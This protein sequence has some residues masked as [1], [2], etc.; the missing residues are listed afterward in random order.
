M[1]PTSRPSPT[2]G[3]P[4]PAPPPQL[5]ITFS[6]EGPLAPPTLPLYLHPLYPFL[7]V[8]PTNM[9]ALICS[10]PLHSQ[11]LGFSEAQSLSSILSKGETETDSL[12]FLDVK[13]HPQPALPATRGRC[14]LSCPAQRG[15]RSRIWDGRKGRVKALGVWVGPVQKAGL[16]R[17]GRGG[18]RP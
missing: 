15:P 10:P 9:P 17:E 6:S 3:S 8:P 1:S 7:D 14:R 12:R 16:G 13:H 4:H 18:E 11:P 2:A 5:G